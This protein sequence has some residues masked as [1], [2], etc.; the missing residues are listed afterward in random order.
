MSRLSIP[1]SI[2]NQRR[3]Q[4][5]DELRVNIER[6]ENVDASKRVLRAIL[7]DNAGYRFVQSPEE[8]RSEELQLMRDMPEFTVQDKL[9]LDAVVRDYQNGS[10]HCPPSGK[11]V[12]Y[13]GGQRKTPVPVEMLDY[14]IVEMVDQWLAEGATGRIWL[15]QVS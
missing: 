12:V 13:F 1:E 10:L 15:E 5:I 11:W 3:D 8:E 14:P 9:N 2:L 7:R 4:R 6:G